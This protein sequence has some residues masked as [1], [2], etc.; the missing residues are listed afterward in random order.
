MELFYTLNNGIN[1]DNINNIF[2]NN[3]NKNRIINNNSYNSNT[4]NKTEENTKIKNTFNV[5][6][7]QHAIIFT[8][9]NTNNNQNKNR[10]KFNKNYNSKDYNNN[11]L[12]YNIKKLY[13]KNKNLEKIIY[14]LKNI[15][16][17]LKEEKEKINKNI[18]TLNRFEDNKKL[19]YISV[20]AIGEKDIEIIGLKN[21]LEKITKLNEE[22]IKKYTNKIHFFLFENYQ[23]KKEIHQK[24]EEFIQIENKLKITEKRVKETLYSIKNNNFNNSN[25]FS[26][27]FGNNTKENYLRMELTYREKK[28]LILEKIR[29]KLKDNHNNNNKIK[30]KS[31]EKN[32]INSSV[33]DIGSTI[34]TSLDTLNNTKKI[35]VEKKEDTKKEIIINKTEIKNI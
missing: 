6:I 23:L 4:N 5:L 7:R 17:T 3:D 27:L 25:K 34:I 13:A 29:K 19:G 10:K 9:I 33:N 35:N 21:Q 11:Y 18:K 8:Y 24:N 32:L 30:L 22:K 12:L 16:S 14:L 31:N 2:T 1:E 20:D 26:I 15:I 28:E